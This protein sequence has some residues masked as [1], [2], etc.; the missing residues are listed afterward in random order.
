MD[1]NGG[2]VGTTADF[3]TPI[4]TCCPRWHYGELW[5]KEQ[6]A[7]ERNSTDPAVATAA[8]NELD[9][10]T[11]FRDL[12]RMIV[13]P[14]P[15]VAQRIHDNFE[16]MQLVPGEF[17]TAHIRALY[18]VKDRPYKD[19]ERMAI[20]AINCASNMRPGGPFFV[21][22]DSTHALQTA[23]QYGRSKNVT[24]V[25][26]NHPQQPLHVDFHN[27]SDTTVTPADFYDGFVDMYLMGA[28]RCAATGP[29]GF[30][31]WGHLL[32][33][34]STCIIHHFG[35]KSRNCQWDDGSSSKHS[36]NPPGYPSEEERLRLQRQAN[37]QRQ[38]PQFHE[39]M[40]S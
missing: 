40:L 12:W 15:P 17:V 3:S 26:A 35:R 32:G 8:A 29:G 9:I 34:N 4:F 18:A 6:V 22:S 10:Y 33:Y 24:V 30:A 20:N 7:A 27:E 38:V 16:R 28:T 13:T 21:A 37:T 1:T 11:I 14:S 36:N 31:R 5:W 39:P 2:H 25:S 23:I 19:I